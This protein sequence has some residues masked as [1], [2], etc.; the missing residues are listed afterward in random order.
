MPYKI[1]IGVWF[2]D[3]PTTFTCSSIGWLLQDKLK[4]PSSLFYSTASNNFTQPWPLK[5]KPIG[6]K[7]LC[8]PQGEDITRP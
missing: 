7:V 4:I 2:I 5:G 3:H 8:C 6:T 1:N